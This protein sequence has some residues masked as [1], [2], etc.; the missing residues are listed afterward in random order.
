MLASTVIINLLLQ[1][2]TPTVLFMRALVILVFQLIVH[3][4]KWRQDS[5]TV[6]AT[7][8]GLIGLSLLVESSISELM[9]L[10]S[11]PNHLQILFLSMQF[12]VSLV[13]TY[14]LKNDCSTAALLFI[15][16]GD[17]ILVALSHAQYGLHEF[18]FRCQCFSRFLDVAIAIY[19]HRLLAMGIFHR[20]Y[21]Y[22]RTRGIMSLSR[23][24]SVCC[25]SI[26]C[27]MTGGISRVPLFAG[28]ILGVNMVQLRT[29]ELKLLHSPI[30]DVAGKVIE[31][32][33]KP[34]N[35]DDQVSFNQT[36]CPICF[37]S[38]VT[39]GGG[40]AEVNKCKHVFHR[41]CI[42]DWL[43]K[44]TRCPVCHNPAP[45]GNLV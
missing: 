45:V 30:L 27:I 38:D 9:G 12:G 36:R 17:L 21:I 26:F 32:L 41:D 28:A 6:A 29:S 15:F 42:I 16:V 5:E 13:E 7:F 14:C 39:C 10:D 11:L 40:L 3:R 22:L 43:N 31:R 2:T 8:F 4:R 35:W 33:R 24:V 1:M 37:E 19:R 20:R 34:K 18:Y 44:R 25:A 23:A